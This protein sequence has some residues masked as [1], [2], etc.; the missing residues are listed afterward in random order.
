MLGSREVTQFQRE[1]KQYKVLV[2]TPHAQR[3]T[4]D[5]LNN[6]SLRSADDRLLSP[7]TPGW[8]DEGARH[9]AVHRNPSPRSG[10]VPAPWA[11]G[12]YLHQGVQHPGG[13][14]SESWRVKG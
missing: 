8:L 12:S 5:D 11:T 9:R 6:T 10:N 7:P 3:V 14:R 13:R 1:G 4:P 2:Q